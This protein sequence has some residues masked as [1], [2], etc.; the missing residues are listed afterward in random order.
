[1]KAAV[2]AY[3][4]IGNCPSDAHNLFISEDGFVRQMSFLSRRRR[5][6]SLADV[7]EHPD[8]GGVAI[9]FDDAYRSVYRSALPVLERFGFPATVFLPT[10]Y[11]GDENRWDEPT[12]CPLEIMDETE[13]KD[14]LNRGMDVQSHGHRHIDMTQASQEDVTEDLQRSAVVLTDLLGQRPRYLA[15]P[16]HTASPQAQAA[17]RAAGFEAAFSIDRVHDGAYAF[18]RVQVTPRDSSLLFRLKTTGRYLTIRHA[19]PVAAGYSLLKR[20]AR[21]GRSR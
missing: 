18:E 16:F 4:A 13:L 3:H 2:L 15:Y 19:P 9:T 10:A 21:A 11:V 5:V 20:A 14:A 7:V 12:G 8:R 6:V 1:M 17:A